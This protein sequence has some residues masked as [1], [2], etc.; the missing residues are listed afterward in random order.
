MAVILNV[1]PASGSLLKIIVAFREP[2]PEPDC[3]SK[4]VTR[5]KKKDKK[6]C[7]RMVTNGPRCFVGRVGRVPHQRGIR[8]GSAHCQ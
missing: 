7:V 5:R 1:A 8:W 3:L 6:G 2:R 4:C